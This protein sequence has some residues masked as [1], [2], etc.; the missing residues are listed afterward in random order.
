M[1]VRTTIML[2]AS[3]PSDPGCERRPSDC[4]LEAEGAVSERV[5]ARSHR[6]TSRCAGRDG[7]FH[8]GAGARDQ[9]RGA[10]ALPPK[11][12]P[13]YGALRL[14]PFVPCGRVVDRYSGARIWVEASARAQDRLLAGSIGCRH[15]R[16]PASGEMQGPARS[17]CRSRFG[18]A[19]GI[20]I[21][22]AT[23]PKAVPARVAHVQFPQPRSDEHGWIR[24]R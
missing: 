3:V 9:L 18:C 13:A 5:A 14:S 23:R 22:R 11:R 19:A 1:P 7:S 17:R 24:A 2:R 10:A 6:P 16:C 8:A 15:G 20:S 12:A 4:C 21:A